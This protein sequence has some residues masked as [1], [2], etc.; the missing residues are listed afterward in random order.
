MFSIT[1]T[2]EVRDD[3]VVWFGGLRHFEK[4]FPCNF[5]DL[6]SLHSFDQIRIF[7]LTVVSVDSFS[8]LQLIHL[9]PFIING[10]RLEMFDDGFPRYKWITYRLFDLCYC[11]DF[12]VS[13]PSNCLIFRVFAVK[14]FQI[15][16]D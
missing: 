6:I 7:A 14:H 12:G 8:F 4:T 9:I 10:R 16:F 3:Y 13:M 11:F 2:N 15:D 1:L 5:S